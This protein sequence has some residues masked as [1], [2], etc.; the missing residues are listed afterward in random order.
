MDRIWKNVIRG[1]LVVVGLAPI[2]V[3]TYFALFRSLTREHLMLLVGAELA[4][5]LFTFGLVVLHAIVTDQ[6]RLDSILSEQSG[7]ASISRFQ[8]LIFTFTIALTFVYLTLCG[9]GQFPAVPK[10]VLIL[11]GI[12]ASTYG[13][14]KGLQLGLGSGSTDGSQPPAAPDPAPQSPAPPA[15]TVTNNPGNN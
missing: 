11:L 4:T 15:S 5:L 10:E 13:V 3:V 7:E 9:N 14:G 2:V 1:V 6:I 8:L 12:S